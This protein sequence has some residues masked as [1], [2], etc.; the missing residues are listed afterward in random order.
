MALSAWL[1]LLMQLQLLALAQAAPHHDSRRL[2]SAAATSAAFSLPRRPVEM[3]PSVSI[4]FLHD[5]LQFPGQGGSL[6]SRCL[7][8]LERAAQLNN[9][10]VNFVSAPPPPAC[11]PAAR[12]R[13][14]RCC[15]A[16][17]LP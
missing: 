8:M 2:S 9:R 4:F 11:P 10:R 7:A 17:L 15:P 14:Y 6:T 12:T 1:L 5:V 16:A 13:R 3:S